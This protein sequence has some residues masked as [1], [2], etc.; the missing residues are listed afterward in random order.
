MKKYLTPGLKV[1]VIALSFRDSR[2]KSSLDWNALYGRG[3]GYIYKGI[4]VG[5]SKYG[6]SEDNISFINYFEDSHED[7]KRKIEEANVLYFLGG[8]P[9]KMMERIREFDL[10][11]TLKT[12]DGIVMG[13]SA[14]A[15]IQ[16]GQYHLSPDDDYPGFDYYTGLG[17]LND[18][19]L[20]VH[21]EA[22]EAQW[23]SIHRVICQKHKRVYAT[24]LMK[25][26]ILVD[27]GDIKLLGEVDVFEE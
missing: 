3:K 24:N 23:E 21:Y 18:F 11:D 19:Y 2:V 6:I 7:A 13:Y 26:A 17:Y 8:L 9:D 1:A 5:L 12:F 16:L 4:V 20:E 22:T 25:G 14:G 27:N 15:V 10:I